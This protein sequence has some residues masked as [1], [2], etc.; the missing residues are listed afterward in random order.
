MDE[1]YDPEH[2]DDIALMFLAPDLQHGH[3]LYRCQ[4]IFISTFHGQDIPQR[5]VLFL[6][7]YVTVAFHVER[8][9][10]PAGHAAL[11]RRSD[12][13]SAVVVPAAVSDIVVPAAVSDVVSSIIIGVRLC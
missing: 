2:R 8:E 7:L 12:A 11:P 13:V 6:H 3:G 4:D 10:V 9:V 5:H 1:L